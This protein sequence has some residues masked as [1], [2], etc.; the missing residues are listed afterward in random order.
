MPQ[1]KRSGT[2][3]NI[4]TIGGRLS[5]ACDVRGISPT[6]LEERLVARGEMTRGQMSRFISNERQPMAATIASIARELRCSA[7]WLLC[8]SNAHFDLLDPI[9]DAS[10]AEPPAAMGSGFRALHV[11]ATEDSGVIADP[12]A[13]KRRAR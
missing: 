7:D 12:V 9:D 2:R 3:S 1:G 10:D 11:D 5:K 6:A 4:L 8:L 13:P